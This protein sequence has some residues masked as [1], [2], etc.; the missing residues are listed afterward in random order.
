V[1]NSTSGRGLK[2]QILVYRIPIEVPVQTSFGIMHDRPSLLIRLE[3]ADGFVGW[4][5]VWCNFPSVGAEHR[6]RL[7]EATVLPLASAL[8]GLDDPARLWA[9]LTVRLRVLAIQTGEHGPLNQCIAGFECAL[10]DLAARRIRE[11]LWRYL[12]PEANASVA[13]Y[14]SGINPT[15]AAET[16]Q[17]ALE[18]GYTACKL[19]VGF[20]R[21]RDAD[22]LRAARSLLGP[23]RLLMADANQGW[24]LDQALELSPVVNEVDLA[25]L[26]EP[27]AHD[28]PDSEWRT[29]ADNIRAPLAAGE[30]FS[31][32]A[33]FDT[34]SH[35]RRVTVLQPDLGKWG[36]VAQSMRVAKAAQAN[37]AAYCPHWLGGGIGLLTSLHVKAAAGGKGSVEVDVNPNHMRTAISS[38][39]LGSLRSGRVHLLDTPGIGDVQVLLEQFSSRL[40][41]KLESSL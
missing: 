3:D 38:P 37:G 7:L 26:E 1:H 39:V 25:W 23:D 13:V 5:E 18:A 14:A 36:G 15:G 33:E 28:T 30:N 34:L 11:P 17:Q 40:T 41:L 22:N 19:K 12:A 2:V 16:V 29:L 9:D 21:E 6:A 24:T 8:G 32:A 31:S 4:G 20:G 27:L 10:Q 35:A